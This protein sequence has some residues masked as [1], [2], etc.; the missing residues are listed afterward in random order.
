MKNLL[1]IYFNLYSI[2]FRLSYLLGLSLYRLFT[3]FIQFFY[4]FF[5]LIRF[6]FIQ[7]KIFGDLKIRGD[8]YLLIVFFSYPRRVLSSLLFLLRFFSRFIL[9]F[10]C[11]LKL[12]YG[13]ILLINLRLMVR[14]LFF[15]G[16]YS[17]WSLI[18]I[19]NFFIVSDLYCII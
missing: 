15:D 12:F 2:F 17:N 16:F 1:I 6:Y 9:F 10:I 13:F 3:T 19:E 11:Y 18:S 14:N 5:L 4:L 7:L 8:Y